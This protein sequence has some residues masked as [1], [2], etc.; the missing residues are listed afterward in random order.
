M[1]VQ[2]VGRHSFFPPLQ[3]SVRASEITRTESFLPKCYQSPARSTLLSE[4]RSTDD[5][6]ITGATDEEAQQ[7]QESFGAASTEPLSTFRPRPATCTSSCPGR[8]H[9]GGTGG[10]LAQI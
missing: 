7:L 6:L 8:S 1:D 4:T 5:L 10:V 9:Q 3:Q 2:N